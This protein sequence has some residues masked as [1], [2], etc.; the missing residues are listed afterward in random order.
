MS[1]AS[2]STQSTKE[3]IFLPQSVTLKSRAVLAGNYDPAKTTVVENQMRQILNAADA[4]SRFGLGSEIHRMALYFDAGSNKEVELYAFPLS[5]AAGAVAQTFT[6][7]FATNA[8]AAGTWYFRIGSY[9]NADLIQIPV[10][11]DDTPDSQAAALATAITSNG[12]IP[13]TAA[14]V[15]G[16][17]TITAKTKSISASEYQITNNVGKGESES[18]GLT[19]A[20]K[21]PEGTTVVIAADVSGL[22]EADLTPLWAKL[23]DESFVWITDVVTPYDSTLALDGARNVCGNPNLKTGLYG[24]PVYKPFNSWTAGNEAGSAGLTNAIALGDSRKE[25]DPCGSRAELPSSPEVGFEA[26][27]Y[28]AGI[29]SKSAQENAALGYTAKQMPEL[30]GPLVEA[31]DWTRQSANRDLAV[32]AGIT[33]IAFLTGVGS[34]YDV[35]AYWHP[36]TSEVNAPF[37]FIVNQRKIW[38]IANALK[39]YQNSSS[40]QD[41]PTVADVSATDFDANAIDTDIVAADV[42]VLADQWEKKAWIYN[43]NFTIVNLTVTEDSENPD[44]YVIYVPTITSGNLRQKEGNVEVTRNIAAVNVVI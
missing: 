17:V 7:T 6:L 8:T 38:N 1:G 5:E 9:R 34:P 24:A 16:V 33:P 25:N 30:F 4:A 37:K 41:R 40:L 23:E 11:V 26:A 10:S 39:T 44:K 21:S 32:D 19:E 3:A 15:A 36:L 14:A 12:N 42:S 35:S 27:A 43:A 29:V 20:E 31:D 22:G 13:F 2:K 28:T 18:G